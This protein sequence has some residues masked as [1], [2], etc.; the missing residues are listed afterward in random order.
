MIDRT[1]QPMSTFCW[2]VLM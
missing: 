1:T 2:C